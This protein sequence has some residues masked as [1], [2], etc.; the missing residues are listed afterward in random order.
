MSQLLPEKKKISIPTLPP[1]GYTYALD[2]FT[3][4][5]VKTAPPGKCGASCRLCWPDPFRE[6]R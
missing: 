4:D 6:G 5:R 1:E 3:G 2:G